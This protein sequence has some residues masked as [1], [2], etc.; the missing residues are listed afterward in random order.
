MGLSWLSLLVVVLMIA[1]AIAAQLSEYQAVG[2]ANVLA[3]TF[4]AA[5]YTASYLAVHVLVVEKVE[6]RARGWQIVLVRGAAVV[7]AVIVGTELAARSMALLGGDVADHRSNYFPV[8]FAVTAAAAVLDYGYSQL[9]RRAKE[10]E[11]R[12]E[13]AR[14]KA[15]DAEL[16]ALRARTDPHFLFNSLNTLA[17]LIEEDPRKAT[18][19]LERLAGLFRYALEGSRRESVPFGDE[20]RAVRGYLELEATRFGDRFEWNIEVEDGLLEL[21]VPPLFLQPVVENAVI[22]GVGPKRGPGRISVRAWLGDGRLQIEVEDD[23]AG[24]GSSPVRGSGS[25]MSDLRERLELLYGKDA[26]IVSGR[27]ESGGVRVT[28]ILPARTVQAA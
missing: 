14:R 21:D 7:A 8:G 20:I 10:I 3:L 6:P 1:L 12:E 16:A 4:I 9:K 17:G 13:R 23:G 11:L 18:E 25:S 15:I 5:C 27:G 19:F 28:I 22:H 2:L 24:M 26:S